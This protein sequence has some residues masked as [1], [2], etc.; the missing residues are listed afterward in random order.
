MFI[1][2][3]VVLLKTLKKTDD[4]MRTEILLFYASIHQQMNRKYTTNERTRMIN[5]HLKQGKDDICISSISVITENSCMK[6][7]QVRLK[8]LYYFQFYSS[9]C[10]NFIKKD[11]PELSLQKDAEDQ[12]LSSRLEQNR[13]FQNFRVRRKVLHFQ[14]L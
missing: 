6:R 3:F 8:M 4:T 10:Y 7:I 12:N 13:K 5:K 11:I 1:L 9:F 14:G 2:I